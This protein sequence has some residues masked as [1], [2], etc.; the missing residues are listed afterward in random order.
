MIYHDAPFTLSPYQDVPP[1]AP[2]SS[3]MTEADAEQV[4]AASAEYAPDDTVAVD[5]SSAAPFEVDVTL[6]PATPFEDGYRVQWDFGQGGYEL[7]AD[8]LDQ[9]YAYEP[10]AGAHQITAYV[11]QPGVTTFALGA[12]VT[13]D[14]AGAIV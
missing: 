7:N 6:T 2:L 5:V 12:S 13:F 1:A 10:V 14:D 9:H 11:Q 3:G 4:A 8:D